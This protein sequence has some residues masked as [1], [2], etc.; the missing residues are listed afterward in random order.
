MQVQCPARLADILMI[1]LLMT[2]REVQ[3]ACF[4]RLLCTDSFI[5]AYSNYFLPVLGAFYRHHA[6]LEG[7]LQ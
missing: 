2:E 4:D 3:L 5:L 7:L 6:H 1:G